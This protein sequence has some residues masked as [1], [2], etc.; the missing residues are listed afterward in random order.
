MPTTCA[1]YN[2]QLAADRAAVFR[3]ACW[4][5]GPGPARCRAGG[6]PRDVGAEH[7][8][9]AESLLLSIAADGFRATRGAT[10]STSP[11]AATRQVCLGGCALPA[12]CLTRPHTVCCCHLLPT[13]CTA[14]LPASP[15]PTLP[16]V[17]SLYRHR[18]WSTNGVG[19]SFQR[20]CRC[21]GRAAGPTGSTA[22]GQVCM[23]KCRE[24]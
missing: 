20:P 19:A 5:A 2:S 7:H 24:A 18:S 16:L 15:M 21:G 10:K 6:V 13:A 11:P 3:Q 17:F 1:R 14:C 8:A 23:L 12:L 22:Q 9:P 4:P